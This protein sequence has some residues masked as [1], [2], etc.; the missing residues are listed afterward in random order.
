MNL[1][2]FKY[3]II[4]PKIKLGTI[5]YVSTLEACMKTLAAYV[6]KFRL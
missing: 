5:F 6:W 1:L 3:F 4:R 2:F